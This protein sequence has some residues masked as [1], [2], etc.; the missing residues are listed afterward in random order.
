MYVLVKGKHY[1]SDLGLHYIM[2]EGFQDY[3]CI[4]DFEADFPQTVSPKILN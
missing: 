3:S 1:A 2:G 4:Q